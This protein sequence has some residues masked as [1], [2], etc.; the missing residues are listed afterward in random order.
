M[1]RMRTGP[2]V[3]LIVIAVALAAQ[4]RPVRSEPAPPPE[5]P[6]HVVDAVD[7]DARLA[8]LPSTAARPAAPAPGSVALADANAW[9][10]IIFQGAYDNN[11]ELFVMTGPGSRST[12]L[13][14]TGEYETYPRF[15]R[16]ATAIVYSSNRAGNTDIWL[17]PPDNSTHTQL[18]THTESDTDPS[19]SPDGRRIVFTSYRDGPAQIYVM[20]SDGAGQRALTSGPFYHGQAAWSPDGS[21]IAYVSTAGGTDGRIWVMNADGTNPTVL[22]NQSYGQHPVWST[23]GQQIAYDTD[24]DKDGWQEIWLM[25][26]NGANQR[27]IY[28]SNV[29][30]TLTDVWPRSW[31]PDG[32]YIAFTRVA[33]IYYQGQWYWMWAHTEALNAAQ[34]SSVIRLSTGEQDW[35][36]DWQT[37]DV[38]SPTSSVDALPA[39]SPGPFTVSWRGTDPGP[40]GLQSFDVQMKVGDG[41]WT[42]WRT[43]T[44]ATSASVAGEGGLSYAFR[45]RARDGAGNLEP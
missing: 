33:Y 2:I 3:L 13:T 40:A 24:G 32:V 45:C 8:R 19:W 37:A 22:S 10:R 21:K 6:A 29:S 17:M 9:S 41:P 12:R 34:P 4:G 25:A 39:Q 36:P 18:T 28:K 30:N 15:N 14:V 16:G 31:S 38:W 35:Y 20:D 26:A 5:R 7:G 43:R 27:M 1:T 23:D 42:D 11:W 44:N